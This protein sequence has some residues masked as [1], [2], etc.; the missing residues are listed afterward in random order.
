MK[1]IIALGVFALSAIPAQAGVTVSVGR[2]FFPSRGVSV[3]FNRGFF[4]VSRGISF[5][6]FSY[7][8]GFFPGYSRAFF[9]G[10]SYGYSQAFFPGYSYGYS[11]APSAFY[12][13]VPV[14]VQQIPVPVPAA[15][16]VPPMSYAPAAAPGVG[17]APIPNV[18]AIPTLAAAEIQV[19]R[20][21]STNEVRLAALQV[22]YGRVL[23]QRVFNHH[24]GPRGINRVTTTTTRTRTTIR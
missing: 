2:G 6:S 19:L 4:P 11:Y 14:P 5:N 1:K 9:P 8:R 23:G 7:S 20:G 24:F 21:Y 15:E 13:P 10:Y 22:R 12:V 17:Y 16:P 18:T 3:G